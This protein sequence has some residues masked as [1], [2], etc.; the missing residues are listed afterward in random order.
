MDLDVH[1]GN[2]TAKIF[3]NDSQVFTF[4]MHG[5]GNYPVHKEA[6]DLDV[7]LPDSIDDRHYLQLLD[8]HWPRLLDEVEPDMVF[9]QCG[10]DILETDK[11]GRLGISSAGCAERDRRILERATPMSSRWCAAWVAAIPRIFGTSW[12]PTAIRFELRTMREG[13]VRLCVVGKNQTM[14]KLKLT[15]WASAFALFLAGA[16]RANPLAERKTGPPRRWRRASVR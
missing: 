10:V 9:Y 5:A 12:R 8:A 4:S 13:R 14:Q 1:Q 3:E 7:G 6:S 11:L 16:Q 2:G 15:L